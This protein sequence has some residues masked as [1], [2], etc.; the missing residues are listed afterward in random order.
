[1][2]SRSKWL[3]PTCYFVLIAGIA[4]CQAADSPAST[5]IVAPR[6]E[7]AITVAAPAADTGTAWLARPDLLQYDRLTGHLFALDF[8]NK[9]IVEF[10]TSGELVKMYAGRVGSGP[11][12]V[13]NP[14]E[15]TLTPDHLFL[16]DEGRATVLRYSRSG[17][18]EHEFPVDP[19]YKDISSLVTG[20]L[21]MIPS[22]TPGFTA[23]VIDP[24][25]GVIGQVGE[26]DFGLGDCV[27]ACEVHGL[28]GGG[29]AVL[30]GIVPSLTVIGPNGD[31]VRTIEFGQVEDLEVWREEERALMGEHSHQAREQRAIG[32]KMWVW[33]MSIVGPTTALLNVLPAKVH[34]RG[35]ELWLVDLESG[36]VVRTGYDR[37]TV[38]NSAALGDALYTIDVTDAGVYRYAVNEALRPYTAGHQ[39]Q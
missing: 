31:I 39:S 19:Q 5:E 33:D 25:G 12:E 34:E 15:F 8:I 2:R 35:R 13:R 14:W 6:L 23:D 20:D 10:T 27:A 36:D 29:F 11:Q 21:V 38:G 30:F 32:G 16:W 22:A 7:N 18:F 3:S 26:L 9:A 17:E 37:S 24:Q 1:M 4:G 28:A